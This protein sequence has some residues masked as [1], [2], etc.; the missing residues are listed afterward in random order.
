M[1]AVEWTKQEYARLSRTID[2]EHLPPRKPVD[3]EVRIISIKK[4]NPDSKPVKPEKQ[5]AT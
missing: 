1:N 5:T 4:L 2:F 3:Y